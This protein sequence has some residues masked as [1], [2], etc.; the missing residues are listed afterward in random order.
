[1]AN[2]FDVWRA[3]TSVG[4][5][6]TL[7]K[8]SGTARGRRGCS[9]RDEGCEFSFT[10]TFLSFERETTLTAEH[11]GHCCNRLPS[12]HSTT[13]G[14]VPP[15]L[16]RRMDPRD[17]LLKAGDDGG[18]RVLLQPVHHFST[19]EIHLAYTVSTFEKQS[20]VSKKKNISILLSHF[21]LYDLLEEQVIAKYMLLYG[22]TYR[23]AK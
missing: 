11:I 22:Q 14:D 7:S 10:A 15:A 8:T 3:R 13:A 1:M 20:N 6:E 9:F 5:T 16:E 21:G 4:R 12:N 17:S 2:V 18:R 23:N 19:S